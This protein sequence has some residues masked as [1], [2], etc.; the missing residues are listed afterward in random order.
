VL[1]TKNTYNYGVSIPNAPNA[2]WVWDS[3][4][5]TSGCH[6]T[7]TITEYFQASCNSGFSLFATADNLFT[8]SINGQQVL[9]GNNWRQ[10]NSTDI[11]SSIIKPCQQ[12]IM[13]I[14]ATNEG[15]CSPAN[16]AGVIYALFQNTKDCYNCPPGQA[17]NFKTCSC[18]VTFIFNF[19][20]M[21]LSLV[22]IVKNHKYGLICPF[23]IVV[24]LKIFNVQPI[25]IMIIIFALV[26]VFLVY[27]RQI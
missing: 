15:D 7:I 3:K 14:T 11:K 22:V 13:T 25:F 8:I 6:Q 16:P 4:W 19:S 18:A 23:V 20:V 2:V 1:T 17:F 27:V 21:Y 5:N 12:N 10:I 24:V 26:N 9:T